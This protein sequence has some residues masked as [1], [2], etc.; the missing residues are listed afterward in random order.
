LL[1]S[2]GGCAF[3]SRNV[4][5]RVGSIAIPLAIV[6]GLLV[7]DASPAGAESA[8]ETAGAGS[9]TPV[10]LY[11][12]G[13]DA[14]QL[15]ADRYAPVVYLRQINNNICDTENE[16]FDP[17]AV[18]F[19]LGQDDIPLRF[20]ESGEPAGPLQTVTDGPLSNDLYGRDSAHFLDFPGTPLRPGCVYRQY[21]ADRLASEDV[22]HVAYAHIYQEPGTDELALQYWMF[23]YFNDWNNDHEGDWEMIM[24][25]F[26]ADSAEEALSQ[27]PTRVVYAQ[28][29]G[30]ERADWGDEILSL[31]D[32]RPVVYSARGAH[33][34]FFEQRVY[35]GL[36]E[37]GTGF[38]CETTVGPHRR[39]ALNAIVVPHEPSGP[40]DPFAWL[41]FEGRWGEM[42]RSEWN[43]PTGPNDKTS[44]TQPVTW[45]EGVRD[46]SLYV[47]TFEG[48]GQAPIGF[49]CGMISGGS[50]V[51]T[52]FTRTPMLV[53]G[54]LGAVV[55]VA[56]WALTT[57]S[58]TVRQAFRFYRKNI[59]TFALIGALLIPTGY[60]IALAQTLLFRIP[61]IEPFLNMM[62]R[63]P[64][65]RILIL[66][67]LGSVQ[68]A[69]ALIFISPAV[70][71]A[72]GQIRQGR[73]PG[74]IESFRAGIPAI[75]PVL[76]ARLKVA[77]RIVLYAL[78]IV[79]IPWALLRFARAFYIPQ[80]VIYEADD[81]D[82]AIHDSERVAN[83]N[84]RRTVLT[85]LVL[86]V[87][88]LLT[89][90]ILAIFLLLAIPS[91]PVDLV[92]YVSSIV[93]ALV[94][95]LS[96]IGM[97]LLYNELRPTVRTVEPA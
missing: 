97:S 44:W 62:E 93:F 6:L 28:H 56:S 69:L 20:T 96:A 46:T 42:R 82:E 61:P 76:L 68:V 67:T 53:M 49:F 78:S 37:N 7:S 23:Y 84:L 10:V 83:V 89:G 60:I 39:L 1:K 70:I 40:D 58:Q 92:N 81:R 50:T 8:S 63:F 95:P 48:F 45:G 38:G 64:G 87:V 19:V 27:E 17:I 21:Y 52:A 79:G 86:S 29:G 91:R 15:L 31:E 18:D 65:I 32:G 90:P 59:R 71:W 47:P 80:A 16:G 35:L 41:A 73:T 77:L 75:L 11:Q 30:G 85:Q 12:Q 25:F 94:Y 5:S 66:L 9:S 33:A 51:L 3:V 24:L 13:S 55:V 57:A 34:S 74:A 88:T 36:V 22:Q 43:G 4:R 26:D 2:D 72:M 14:E 54:I